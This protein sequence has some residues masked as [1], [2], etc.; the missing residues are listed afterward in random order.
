MPA[1]KIPGWI[2]RMLL[3]RLSEIS[4]EIR[5]LDTKIDSLRNETKAEVE[6]LRKEIQYRFEATDSKFETLNAKIDSL[7]KR[8][9]VIEEITALKIKIA[10]I[11]KR[12][13]VAET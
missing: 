6:S 4:G 13:A 7:D 8:I 5:A 1:E 9:P 3:P 2:E 12:L 10:D 11:E